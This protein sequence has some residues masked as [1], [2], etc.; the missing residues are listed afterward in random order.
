VLVTKNVIGC[1]GA[2]APRPWPAGCPAAGGCWAMTRYDPGTTATVNAT[3][4][5][6]ILFISAPVIFKLR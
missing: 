3:Q 5:K 6:R 2:A 1:G 4:T